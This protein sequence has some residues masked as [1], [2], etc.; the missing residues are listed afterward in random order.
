MKTSIT[1]TVLTSRA[2]YKEDHN[3]FK[4]ASVLITDHMHPERSSIKSVSYDKARHLQGKLFKK[5]G[6][7][8]V[9]ENTINSL[10]TTI[11]RKDLWV[12]VEKE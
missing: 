11:C 10:D 1:I 4:S 6:E 5:Y 12:R 9:I 3:I 7:K 2:N 8:V